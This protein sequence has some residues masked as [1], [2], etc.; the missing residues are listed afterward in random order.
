MEFKSFFTA[1]VLQ[2]QNKIF[3]PFYKSFSL[4][5]RINIKDNFKKF[6]MWVKGD[7]PNAILTDIELEHQCYNEKKL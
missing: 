7:M 2:I 6:G 1:P 3:L 5:E 4:H